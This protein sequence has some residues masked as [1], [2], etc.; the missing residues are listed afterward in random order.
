MSPPSTP[1]QYGLVEVEV[2]FLVEGFTAIKQRLATMGA[3][4]VAPRVFERN[5]RF[6]TLDEGLLRRQEL[7]RLRQDT[8]SRLT[9]KGPSTY[10]ANSEAKIREEIELEIGDFSRMAMILTRLGFQP[11]QTYEKYRETFQWNEVEIVLDEMPFGLFIELEGPEARIKDAASSLGLDWSNRVLTNY[12]AIMELARQKF[13][14]PFSDLTF[15]NF[16]QRPV[17]LG[18]IFPVCAMPATE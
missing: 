12:L 5:T 3:E 2:K 18:K 9:F 10:D 13:H 11:M 7:L 8:R 15:N 4:L 16:E 17:D 14:L 1:D 6:D